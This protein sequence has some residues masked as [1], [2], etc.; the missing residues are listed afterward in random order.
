MEK[1]VLNRRGFLK[2]AA[3]TAAGAAL[4]SCAPAQV[5]TPAPA[6]AATEAPTV[7]PAALTKDNITLRL[8]HWDNFLADG[9][10]PAFEKFTE[11]YPNIKVAIE[12]T[13]YNE[14]SQKVAAA[15]A[16]GTPPDVTGTVAE[17]FTNMAGQGQLVDLKPFIDST[18][19]NIKDFHAGNLSQNS[20]GGKLL[21]IPYSCDG[22]WWFFD[23]DGFKKAGLKTPYEYWKEGNWT[24]DTANELAKKL[25][26]GSGTDKVFGW[27][28]MGTGNYFE[29]LPY[30][31]SNTGG[32][33]IFDETYTKCVLDDPKAMEVYQWGYDMRAYA[34][35]P[36]DQQNGTPASGRVMQWLDWS[37]YALVYATQ[38]P[39][40][41][42]YAPPPA[43]PKTKSFVFCGDA[44]GFGILKG[45]KHPQES[46]A[47]IDWMMMPDTLELIFDKTGQEPPRLGLASD[48][49]IWKRN[50]AY[51]DAMIGLELTKA[52]LE[53]SFYNTPKVSNF[54]EMWQAHNEEIS[55]A[56]TDKATL[57]DALKKA[58]DRINGLLKEATV[59]QD[60]L[61]WTKA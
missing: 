41:Y 2:I 39:F 5:A 11:K 53:G 14:Y 40:K 47:A 38:M 52:R 18:G 48:E 30:L 12:M 27:G 20:W 34:P 57:T 29:M 55:L 35:G 50:T 16:G 56:W 33:G 51:P 7:G 9:W 17:H 54:L 61:Y 19:F 60:R 6:A 23:V 45:V 44:P 43:S 24:W 3:T 49:G 8:W 21:S 26:S 25:T 10:K 46:F 59:D 36:E 1:K 28:G 15:I 31:A 42:S 58:T 4:A 13:D 37:P 22:M 32:V